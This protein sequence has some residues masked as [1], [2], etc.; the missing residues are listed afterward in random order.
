MKTVTFG[1]ENAYAL[2]ESVMEGASGGPQTTTS[3]SY[4][5]NTSLVM[6]AT[7]PNGMTTEIT[8]RDDQLRPTLITYPTGATAAASYNDAGQ[9]SSQSVT[10][11]DGG[12]Q[13]TVGGS[14]VYDGLG[15]VIQQVD[16][17]GGQVNTSYDAMGRVSS[18]TNP[19]TAGGSP[20]PSTS[21]TYDDLGRVTVVT[22]PDSQTIQTDYDGSA[23]TVTDQV[24]RK[25]QRV[26]D[27]LGRLVTVNEQDSSG[28]LSQATS[29]SYDALDDLTQ[30]N[31]GGQ[32]R[33]FKY[34]SIGR[35]LYEKIPEQSATINDGT[36]AYWS[37][38]YTYTTFNA[39]STKQDA[40][41]VVTTYSY[42][43]LNRVTQTS[44]NTVSG[45]T[46]APTVT[47][48]YDSDTTYGTS[49]DGMLVRVNVGNRLS[50]AVY[51]RLE[52]PRCKR[53]PNDWKPHVHDRLQLQR[54]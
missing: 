43:S 32:Y 40:R 48:T 45:V 13:R 41:G 53:D 24:N 12:T 54:G 51:L 50:G 11:D 39:V 31:Q 19:F 37:C 14:T 16:A 30:V 38:K 20:G 25:I 15:R 7:D 10:Y 28:S 46:T 5:F 22:L 18:V 2:P 44:Y 52:I 35:L 1:D 33:T 21:Y 8:T 3:T 9:S 4:D 34:D 27:G 36:G 49:A 17:N 42:D 26:T 6:D 47:Y 29:Y 23:I